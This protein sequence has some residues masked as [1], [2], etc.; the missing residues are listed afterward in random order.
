MKKKIIIGLLVL[1]LVCIATGVGY[2]FWKKSQLKYVQYTPAQLS[3]P[4]EIPDAGIVQYN[5]I[6]DFEKP[7]VTMF[8]VDWCTYCRRFMPIFGEVA[9]KYSNKF[10][11]AV[12]NCD[13]PEYMD[14]VKKYR[15]MAFPTVQVID[16]KYDYSFTLSHSST[17]FKQI[18]KEEL[19]NY[20]KFR[21]LIK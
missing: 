13:M 6:K 15:I 12:V 11:F 3:A 9:K 21:S 10:T 18:F 20:Y 14:M 8:Y 16:K 7:I 4:I 1:F 19:M 2:Y 17:A 5:E